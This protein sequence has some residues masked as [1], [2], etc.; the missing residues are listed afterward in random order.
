[1]DAAVVVEVSVNCAVRQRRN[2]VK[3]V[4]VIL[5]LGLEDAVVVNQCAIKRIANVILDL[6]LVDLNNKAVADSQTL[7]ILLEV[8]I[9]E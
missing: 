5:L 9:L 7:H 2:A 8:Q 3:N 6:V 1:V 4:I